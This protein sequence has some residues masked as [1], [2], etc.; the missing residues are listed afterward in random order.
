MSVLPGAWLAF[1]LRLRHFGFGIRLLTGVALSPVVLC[2]QFYALRLAGVSFETTAALLP[3][4]NLPAAYWV[5]KK[6]D[7][8]SLSDKKTLLATALVLLVPLGLLV[9]QWTHPEGRA[10]SWHAWMHTDII[11]MLAN[12][13]LVPEEPELSGVRLGYPWLGHVYLALLSYQLN[14]PPVW[15]FIW[16]NLVW[17]VTICGLAAALIG[18]LGGNRFSRITGVIWLFF[19]VNI[20]GYV[21]EQILPL[22]ESFRLWGDIRYT[23]WFNKLSVLN[24]MPFL[25]GMFL[26]LVYVLLRREPRDLGL[27]RSA[28]AGLLA[29]GIGMA[30]PI[31]L[32][33]V[34]ALLGGFL[35]AVIADAK[36]RT[37]APPA[38]EHR[39]ADLPYTPLLAL[40]A[41]T[42]IAATVTWMFTNAITADRV[43]ATF[44][45]LPSKRET[46]RK[47]LEALIV[48]SPL[49]AGA[50]VALR[51]TWRPY[52]V[53]VMTLLLGAAASLG[54]Y[55]VLRIPNY[56]NEYKFIFTA[57]I[58]LFP[59]T[60][61]A[62]EPLFHRL[63]RAPAIMGRWPA[64]AIVIVLVALP[65]KDS[66]FRD[67]PGMPD[68]LPK[69]DV[70]G[71]DLRLAPGEPFARLCDA[72]RRET[73]T[74]SILVVATDK[75]HLPTLTRRRL[76]APPQTTKVHPGVDLTSDFILTRA[77]GYDEDLVRSRQA[78]VATLVSELVAA[79]GGASRSTALAQIQALGRPLVFV[80]DQQAHGDFLA[81]LERQ[82]EGRLLVE[83][84]GLVV[85]LLN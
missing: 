85:W 53:Q 40:A 67:R 27:G 31:Y 36:L 19:G 57:A 13:D 44:Q 29:V 47:A 15:T 77:R 26:A 62:L 49:L 59:F 8:D 33:V 4:L 74:E 46:L 56:S 38:T 11:Y 18:E 55:V 34:C 10:Y 79:P 43:S 42:L 1:G 22:D 70:S 45:L 6:F 7:R 75:L 50:A 12:G 3:W 20:V 68:P 17:L 76:Y 71:F 16:I 54:C 28:V 58:C 61:L 64:M 48:T 78:L 82:Q 83:D 9:A 81:W 52:R 23:P 51:K 30:Y 73:P 41:A 35:F 37:T 66:M 65:V 14:S 80:V 2:A 63:R 32:P 69:L 72:I 60:A 21:C 5:V 39:R 84:T 24:H 25:L